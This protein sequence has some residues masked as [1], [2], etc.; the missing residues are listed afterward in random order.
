MT[1]GDQRLEITSREVSRGAGNCRPGE[2]DEVCSR[3]SN[4]C[5]GDGGEACRSTSHSGELSKRAGYCLTANGASNT[6]P[7]AEETGTTNKDIA[8]Y[9]GITSDRD[10]FTDDAS[11][12]GCSPGR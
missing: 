9:I 5:S 10:V 12:E 11:R 4:G 3:T 6:D 1:R 7:G 2:G 8:V